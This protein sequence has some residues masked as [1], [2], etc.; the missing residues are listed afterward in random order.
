MSVL[1]GSPDRGAFRE[2]T[3]LTKQFHV[4]ID[5]NLNY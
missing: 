4:V 2:N 5:N 3:P 1:I